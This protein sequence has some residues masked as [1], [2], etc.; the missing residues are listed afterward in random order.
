MDTATAASTQE[1]LS[2][3]IKQVPRS[4]TVRTNGQELL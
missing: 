3:T 1:P 4:G 2:A